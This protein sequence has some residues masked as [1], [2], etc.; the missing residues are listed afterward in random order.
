MYVGMCAMAVDRV[1]LYMYN[2]RIIYDQICAHVYTA[3]IQYAVMNV[4]T[5]TCNICANTMFNNVQC[6]HD[7][8]IRIYIDT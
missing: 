1:L 2:I 5:N 3:C 4:F 8:Y 6:M 7:M